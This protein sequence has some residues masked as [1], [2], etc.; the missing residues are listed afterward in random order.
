MLEVVFK[1]PLSLSARIWLQARLC[2]NAKE[3]RWKYKREVYMAED[4]MSK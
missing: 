1:M 4:I 2:A 3:E